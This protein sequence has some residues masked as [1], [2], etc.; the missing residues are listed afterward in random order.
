MFAQ[1]I[2]V[3]PFKVVF[4]KTFR[5]HCGKSSR[6]KVLSSSESF[7]LI[8]MK[9]YLF[10]VVLQ[11]IFTIAQAW[12][13][14]CDLTSS[15]QVSSTLVIKN[16]NYP[17]R[18]QSGSSCKWYLQAP[19][20]YTIELKC[21]YNLDAPMSDCQSQRFYVSRD[22][23]K[24]LSYAEYF[25]ASSSITRISVG[26]EVSL[27]YTS[28]I[29]GSGSFYCEAKAILTT[30][31]NCQCGWSKTVRNLQLSWFFYN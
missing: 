10:L 18:Y 4:T 20:G 30:Q 26:N 14:T 7:I 11:L 29:G 6:D 2:R 17:N 5:W 9:L 28:N 13:E 3:T 16:T 24:A 12:F 8:I 21:S 1:T 23:D 27:G 15:V 19:T 22:G 25:C 31:D